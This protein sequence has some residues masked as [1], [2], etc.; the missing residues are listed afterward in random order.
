MI[1]NHYHNNMSSRRNGLLLVRIINI[2]IGVGNFM[3][4]TEYRCKEK[5]QAMHNVEGEGSLFERPFMNIESTSTY[6]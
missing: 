6:I 3:Y 5:A 4:N 1:N 2:I